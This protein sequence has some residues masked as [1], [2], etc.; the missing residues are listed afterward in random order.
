MITTKIRGKSKS[1]MRRIWT[2]THISVVQ[3]LK[4]AHKK[5][6]HMLVICHHDLLHQKPQNQ[7]IFQW[8][9]TIYFSKGSSDGRN[10]S[11]LSTF[12]TLKSPLPIWSL[13]SANIHQ[14]SLKNFYFSRSEVSL[15]NRCVQHM[16]LTYALNRFLWR[17]KW[18]WPF[19]EELIKNENTCVQS[20]GNTWDSVYISN[21]RLASSIWRTN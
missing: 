5:P 8:C 2:L 10:H 11:R 15:L 16:C 17:E 9:V 4:V 14:Y 13:I 12:V 1:F 7:M 3:K 20:R 19:L 6:Q 18:K 21:R